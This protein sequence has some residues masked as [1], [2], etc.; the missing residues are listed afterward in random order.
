MP[1]RT[2]PDRT[3]TNEGTRLRT[4]GP[5][6]GPARQAVEAISVLTVNPRVHPPESGQHTP[7]FRLKG[8]QFPRT[9]KPRLP[10]SCTTRG[11]RPSSRSPTCSTCR[12]PRC[13]DTSTARRP[14]PAS[15]RRPPPQSPDHHRELGAGTLGYAHLRRALHRHPDF[16]VLSCGTHAVSRPAWSVLR[17]TRTWSASGPDWKRRRSTR[18]ATLWSPFYSGCTCARCS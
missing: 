1:G 2:N 14:C 10:S 17:A 12:A 6:P 15:R 18:P 5:H 4:R 9:A 7:G 3:P 11:R 16:S 8:L 13:T